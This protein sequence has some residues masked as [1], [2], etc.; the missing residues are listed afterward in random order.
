MLPSSLILAAGLLGDA[1][2]GEMGPLFRL[3]P[4]PV[5][6]A[7]TLIE[8]C[9]RHLNRP[10]RS[11][12]DLRLRGI[13]TAVMLTGLAAAIG[14]ALHLLAAYLNYGWCLEAF[15]LA[16]LVAQRSL[17]SHVRDVSKALKSGGVE[18]GRP[19]VARIVG[20]DVTRLDEYGVARAAIE[21]L[22]ENFG[23]GVVAPVFWYVLLG[24]PGLLGYKMLNTL[25]SMIGY[26]SPH[27]LY[28]G[29]ASARLDD[30]ANLIPARLSGL[31]M[32]LAVIFTPGGNP[33]KALLTMKSDARSHPSPN[34]GWPEAAMAGG[35]GLALGGPRSYQGGVVE[36]QWIG[37]GRARAQTG[38]I[39]RALITF[40]A[41][42]LINAG[43][44]IEVL[45]IVG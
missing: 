20:R 1:A 30:A 12:A 25:D 18:D 24:L 26:R 4:H 40:I 28:F 32:A 29:W 7:G 34:S 41:A 3:V 10:G 45:Q 44:A 31:I 5:V 15:V 13:L 35:L 33:I 23:D 2:L 43:L 9:D 22:A 21:S 17:F 36:G 19:M 27:Y 8:W 6:M 14:F 11:A 38:D 16:V 42:C 39:D 37:S